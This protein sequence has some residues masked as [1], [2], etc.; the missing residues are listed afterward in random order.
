VI[1]IVTPGATFRLFLSTIDH[2]HRHRYWIGWPPVTAPFQE[3]VPLFF[4]FVIWWNKEIIF[5]G[6]SRLLVKLSHMSRHRHR[7]RY[8]GHCR[9]RRGLPNGSDEPRRA[10][11]DIVIQFA[12]QWNVFLRFVFSRVSDMMDELISISP[13][14]SQEIVIMIKR[15]DKSQKQEQM[16]K[17][18]E[19]ER[20]VDCR[21]SKDAGWKG[22]VP[23]CALIY[24][25]YIYPHDNKRRN[26]SN[27]RSVWL[28]CGPD[29]I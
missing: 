23:R 2:R 5:L 17:N 26:I 29:H 27:F 15:Q 3:F 9:V 13:Y 4:V 8:C 28:R 19:G 14:S 25:K 1:R 16:A 11:Y 12:Q 24:P 21:R 22:C 18:Q 10:K 7:H 6:T 20:C